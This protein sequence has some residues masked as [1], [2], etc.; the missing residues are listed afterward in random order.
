M[1]SVASYQY[2]DS[3][4]DMG[5]N[6]NI[7]S[8]AVSYQF[9]DLLV[10]S[11][12][13]LIL[14]SVVSYQYYDSLNDQ[15]T[16]SIIVTPIASYQYFD[17]LSTTEAQFLNSPLVSY[18]YQISSDPGLAALHGRVTDVNGIPL[19]NSFVGLYV[20]SLETLL[21]N[22][23]TDGYYSIPFD[24]GN[25]SLIATRVGY[26]TQ[27]RGL[28]LNANTGEQ[29]FQLET[30]PTLPPLLQVSRSATVSYTVDDLMGSELRIFDGSQFVPITENNWPSANLMT[31]VMTQGWTDSS[32]DP[33]IANT[34]FDGWPMTIANVFATGLGRFQLGPRQRR[35][36]QT[37]QYRD[38]CDDDQKL[39]Q[40]E[41]LF[42]IVNM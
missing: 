26:Q 23:D 29:N 3:L 16:N 7:E 15:G 9:Y 33:S 2:Y 38:D 32:P 14:S 12:N 34:P 11:S 30:L 10:E 42:A 36:K 40:G 39:N 41:S 28:T 22:T 5:T 37:R 4:T 1:S 8:P 17:S 25:Y 6:S 19:N 27:V 18:Y 31:I 24:S 13:S 21:T 20:G 35:Q